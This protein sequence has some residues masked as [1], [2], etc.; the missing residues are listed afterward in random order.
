M[1]FEGLKEKGFLEEK[2]HKEYYSGLSDILRRYLERRSGVEALEK[3]SSEIRADLEKKTFDKDVMD[4]I[5]EVL[6]RSDLVKF[7]KFAPGHEL[8]GKLEKLILDV[9]EKTKPIEKGASRKP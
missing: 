9:V 4:M 5:G 3:T 2:N 7:A 8:A 6:D 1:E